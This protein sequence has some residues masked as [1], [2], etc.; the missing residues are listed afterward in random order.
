MGI[1]K[2]RAQQA[3]LAVAHRFR[4]QL[5]DQCRAHG[6]FL[7]LYYPQLWTGSWRAKDTGYP[8]G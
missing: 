7:V 5:H 3:R 8:T 2:F 1:D 4:Y 6:H